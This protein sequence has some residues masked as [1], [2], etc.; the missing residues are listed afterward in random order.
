MTY[1]PNLQNDE[2]LAVALMSFK[3]NFCLAR[4]V[5]AIKS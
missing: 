4:R 2:I 1:E 5:G 3:K